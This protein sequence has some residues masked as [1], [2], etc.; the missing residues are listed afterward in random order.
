MNALKLSLFCATAALAGCGGS[1][2]DMATPTPPATPQAES[3][4]NWSKTGVFT[5]PAEGV[6]ENMD[7]LVWNFDGNDNPDAY[8][9]LLPP[10][11]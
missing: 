1:D 4:T 5:K 11:T 10:T 9:E 2:Y 6:P 7:T 8:S 3:F